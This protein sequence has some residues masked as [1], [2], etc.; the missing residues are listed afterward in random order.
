MTDSD[1]PFGASW[2]VLV[3]WPK[4]RSFGSYMVQLELARATPGT[5]VNFRVPHI[6]KWP[7]LLTDHG[8]SGFAYGTDIRCYRVHDGEIRGWMQVLDAMWKPG[9]RVLD[10]ASGSFMRAGNY[11]VCEPE[12]HPVT[13]RVPMQGFRGWRWFDRSVVGDA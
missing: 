1:D 13:R 10:P 6:P 11:I 3:T 2:D 4:A 5:V 7:Q 8:E 12:W 9:G